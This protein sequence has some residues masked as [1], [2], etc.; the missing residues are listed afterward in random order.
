MD[1]E[2]NLLSLLLF[3]RLVSSLPS[4]V[5]VQDSITGVLAVVQVVP[6]TLDLQ[7]FCQSE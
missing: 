3:L 4:K 6:M 2:R 7:G 1:Y 5:V